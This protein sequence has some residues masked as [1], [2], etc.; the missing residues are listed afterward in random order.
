MQNSLIADAANYGVLVL[1]FTAALP[2]F[3]IL[4]MTN[5]LIYRCGQACLA[6][7]GGGYHRIINSSLIYDQGIFGG[8]RLRC[9]LRTFCGQGRVYRLTPVR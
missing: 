1:G 6:L 4:E 7:I 5:T 9:W 2:P 8:A 3:P